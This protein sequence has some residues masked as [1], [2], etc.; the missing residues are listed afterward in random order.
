[1]SEDSRSKTRPWF[2]SSSGEPDDSGVYVVGRRYTGA[3]LG[4]I[5]TLAT[6]LVSGGLYMINRE[7]QFHR[8]QE[9]VQTLEK[10]NEA[11]QAKVQSLETEDE[12]LRTRLDNLED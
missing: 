2:S 9:D 7:A 4:L 11:L 1:M 8:L 12:R 5:G 6:V 10:E 3:L